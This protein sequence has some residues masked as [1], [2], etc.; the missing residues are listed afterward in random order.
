MTECNK[1]EELL[2]TNSEIVKKTLNIFYSSSLT[3]QYNTSYFNDTSQSSEFSF[4]WVE[5]LAIP[6]DRYCTR[7]ATS[8]L[9]ENSEIYQS[10]MV[11][12]PLLIAILVLLFPGHLHCI[13]AGF[14]RVSMCCASVEWWGRGGCHF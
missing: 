7:V 12:P 9:T 14:P 5:V 10:R 3:S 11:L 4:S 1:V 8:N 13:G 2:Q 6:T